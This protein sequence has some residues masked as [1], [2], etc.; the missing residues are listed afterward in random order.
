MVTDAEAGTRSQGF[1]RARFVSGYIGGTNSPPII[2]AQP[3]GLTVVE[4]DN[5]TFAVTASGPGP[6]AHQWQFAGLDISGATNTS[7]TRFNTQTN[8][9]G[10]YRVVV[11]N[12][13]GAVTSEVAVL[14]VTLSGYQAVWADDV[15]KQLHAAGQP[16]AV[17]VD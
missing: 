2:T 11:T 13:H 16:G 7:F 1:Y 17:G 9:A 14:T 4:G 12:A 8:H 3:Q 15:L 6:R 10:E 5:A